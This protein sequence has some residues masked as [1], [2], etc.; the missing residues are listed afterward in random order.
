MSPKE[1]LDF[2]K[3]NDARQLDMRFTDLPGLLQ[4][5]SYPITLSESSFRG[6]L[7]HRRLQHSR[8]GG[9]QRKR[10]ADHPRPDHRVHGSLHETRTLVM[11]GEVID[12]ITRQHYERDPRWIA[13][14]AEIVSAELRRRRHGLLRR[15]S[16]VLHLRQR[17]VR[18]ERAFR[19]LLYRRRGRPLELGPRAEQP[20]LPAALQG[21]LLP[22]AADRSLSGSAR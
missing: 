21:R 20:G 5:I 14:K 17:A 22:G 10:H 6:R 1:V 11:L 18:S 9:D 16:G 8:L 19:F 4:H 12:P 3:K 13:K 15:R 7:R 2:A